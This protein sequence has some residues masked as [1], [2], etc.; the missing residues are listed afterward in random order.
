MPP[1]TPTL[2]GHLR[3]LIAPSVPDAA[4]LARWMERRDEAAFA[5]LMARHG[6]M[7]LGVCR[8]VL[9]DAQHAEHAFQ[10]TFLVLARKA[11][12]VRRP[13]ALPGFLYVVVLRLARKARNATRR[14]FMQTHSAIPEPIDPHPHPL[15]AIAGRE[16]LALLDEEIARLPEVFRLPL[17]LCVMQ[18]RR[19]P[20]GR[21][22]R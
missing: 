12:N 1:H 13:E 14:Q 11:A 21:R 9:G 6:P 7:V 16:L 4:L 18:A 22:P 2:L 17:L 10:A 5:A 20:K 15:D 3:R 19:R 8:R